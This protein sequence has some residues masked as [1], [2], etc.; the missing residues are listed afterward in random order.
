MAVRVTTLKGTAAGV[1][2]T[3]ELGLGCCTTREKKNRRAAGSV[4]RPTIS[5]CAVSST[6]SRSCG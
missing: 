2:Y 6:R 4:S 3:H 5:A 1:Y